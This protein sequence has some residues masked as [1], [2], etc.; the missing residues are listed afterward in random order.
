MI[1]ELIIITKIE[2][3]NRVVGLLEQIK[4]DNDKTNIRGRLQSANTIEDLNNVI[5]K[6]EERIKEINDAKKRAETAI[7]SIPTKYEHS[8]TL[9]SKYLQEFSKR[10]L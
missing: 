7:N 1:K 5:I 10:I 3:Y 8:K 6:A 9:K 2:K 4:N